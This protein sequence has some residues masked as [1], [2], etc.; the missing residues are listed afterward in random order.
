VRKKT[1]R[2]TAGK[3]EQSGESR[4]G[5]FW[6][7]NGEPLIDCAPLSEA[8]PYGDHLTHPRGHAEVWERCQ[9]NGAVSPDMEYEE[10]PRGRVMYN[11]RTQRFTL[12]ADRCI[13]RDKNVVRRI[14]SQLHLPRHTE[15]GTD[16][17]YRCFV[18]LRGRTD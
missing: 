2:P 15:T 18:C 13:L 8:E 7:L 11:T 4:V 14:M 12:L 10:P 3:K 16:I 17:H 9:R 1:R 5:I 6:V